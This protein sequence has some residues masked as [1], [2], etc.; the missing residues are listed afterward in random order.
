MSQHD[1]PKSHK[2][3]FKLIALAISLFVALL[4]GEAFVRVLHLVPDLRDEFPGLKILY[5]QD[6]QASY[7]PRPNATAQVPDETGK[8]ITI[9]TDSN[10]MRLD[11][12]AAPTDQP[13]VAVLGDSF[14]ANLNTPN[15]QT[16]CA[17]LSQQL[18]GKPV[19]NFGCLGY[20]NVQEI[21]LARRWLPKYKVDT[22]I[23]AICACNDLG[24]NLTFTRGSK[25]NDFDLEEQEPGR[26]H[27]IAR[28]SELLTFAFRILQSQR[29]PPTYFGDHYDLAHGIDKELIQYDAKL[30]PDAQR[31]FDDAVNVSVDALSDFKKMAD[32]L[33]ARRLVVLI[34]AKAMIYREILFITDS[35][36]DP[37]ANLALATVIR[38]GYDFDRIRTTWQ[39]IADRAH[40]PFFDL[41]DFFREHKSEILY[42]QIDRHWT[43][44]G[45]Q[46]ASQAVAAALKERHDLSA[47]AE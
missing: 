9:R 31:E 20:S 7:V 11:S 41:T 14:I 26:L 43:P 45:Q 44:R 34:P 17:S 27:K 13:A 39:S 47:S 33:N 19:L 40:L 32:Q 4:L 1:L 18:S 21:I 22:L 15:D 37:R 6:A 29:T 10:G 35:Q 12:T 24:D 42:G 25:P 28:H 30:P 46:L 3:L 36:L 16:F 23:L 2:R 5:A 8:L 38:R